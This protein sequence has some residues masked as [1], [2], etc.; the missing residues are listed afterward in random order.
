M[1]AV[2]FSGNFSFRAA[3]M[4]VMGRRIR[5]FEPNVVY[6]TVIRCVDRQFLLKRAP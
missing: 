6:S 4:V 2:H 1:C 3:D 5:V